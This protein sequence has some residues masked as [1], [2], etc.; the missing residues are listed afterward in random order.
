MRID[1]RDLKWR[2]R[3]AMRAA[4]PNALFMTFIYLL[5]TAGLGGVVSWFAA[6]PLGDV[7]NLY[8]QG[9]G[10][11]RAIGLMMHMTGRF[12]IFLALLITAWEIVVDFSYRR[13]CLNT[14]RGRQGA[15]SD[16]FSGFSMVGRILWLRVLILM[17]GFLWYVAIFMPA[18]FL[19]MLGMEMWVW[20]PLVSVPLCIG[21][22]LLAVVVWLTRV[23]RYAMAT[24]CL[25]DEPEMGA[26]W[27]LRRSV[28]MMQ[29]RVKDY[30]L[31]ML[32]FLGWIL[33]AVLLVYAVG[34]V[35]AGVAVVWYEIAGSQAGQWLLLG[36]IFGVLTILPIWIMSLWLN[37]YITI[38]ECN[39]YE[40]IKGGTEGAS[41]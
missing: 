41:V 27:A 29:D 2:A 23:A 10:L 38:T 1:R 39:F 35:L 15:L 8:E 13:W 20:M 11:D 34:L 14:A 28:H 18:G 33:A 12:G 25:A 9:V 30:V 19:L 31:L 17:Y 3:D 37:P 21:V 24:Y 36:A 26:S 40:K 5:L 4:R 16:L 32:S 6:D 7:L 22:F